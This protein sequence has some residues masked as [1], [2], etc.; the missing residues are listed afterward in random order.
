MINSFRSRHMADKLKIAIVDDNAEKRQA[1]A[2]KFRE[3]GFEVIE[4]SNG[5]EGFE[6]IKAA[7]P[8]L[9]ITGIEMPFL[10]GFELI[11]ELKKFPPTAGIAIMVSSHLNREGDEAKAREL[12]AEDFIYFGFVP[13]SEVVSRA[14]SLLVKHRHLS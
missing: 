10:S 3:E 13:L 14:R 12:G 2:V 8:Q 5:K 9:I 7:N 4:A 1:Y 11:R 6:A